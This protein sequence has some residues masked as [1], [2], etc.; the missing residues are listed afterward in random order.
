M[1]GPR[2]PP[3]PLGS[4]GKEV[5]AV[6]VSARGIESGAPVDRFPI[7]GPDLGS[8]VFFSAFSIRAP[9][10]SSSSFDRQYLS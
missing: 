10:L 2:G 5:M 1:P 3:L 4:G 8:V 9:D 7:T 6:E